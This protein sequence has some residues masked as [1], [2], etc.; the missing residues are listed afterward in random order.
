MF[1]F[2]VRRTYELVLEQLQQAR[3]IGIT[4]IKVSL[5]SVPRIYHQAVLDL[6][7]PLSPSHRTNAKFV[8]SI[9]S[10]SE[11]LLNHLTSTRRLRYLLKQTA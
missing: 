1:E 10:W 6:R 4:K 11:D 7:L 3:K 2:P 5:P 8:N 9:F